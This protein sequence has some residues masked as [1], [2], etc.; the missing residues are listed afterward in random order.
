MKDSVATRSRAARALAA[1][2]VSAALVIGGN[3]SAFAAGGAGG[4]GAGAS[5]GGSGAGGVSAGGVSAGGNSGGGSGAGAGSEA[6]LQ[7]QA[8]ELAGEIQADGRN[9]DQLAEAI[10]GAQ[11]RQQQLASQSAALRA[12]MIRTGAEVAA[13]RDALKEQAVLAY[14]A[15]G[16]PLV[17]YVPGRAGQDPSLTVAYAEIVA[18]GQ[19]QV[20]DAYRS[21][22]AKQAAQ[23]TQL[24]SDQQQEAATV[25]QL[26]S[27]RVAA[28]SAQAAR[29]QALAQVKGQ[30]A[31]LVAAVQA[32]QQ[33]AEEAAVSG[34]HPDAAA[35]VAQP[36]PM[37]APAPPATHQAPSTASHLTSAPQGPAP[38]ARPTTTAATTT[39]APPPPTS[40]PTTTPPAMTTGGAPAQAPGANEAL[41]Y[42][43]AQLGKP[44]QWA[45]AGPGSFDCSGLT[46]MAW[47]QAGVYFPHLA[48]DQ[49][50]MTARIA[51][52]QAE[53]GD[54]IFFGTSDNVYHVGIYIGGG[55]MIDAPETGEVVSISSIYWSSLLGA[56]RVVAQ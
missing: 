9:L 5:G 45:G 41:A 20:V 39:T 35:P 36:T 33:H 48:Q 24:A 44:Y 16:A 6:A 54:L 37:A 15:G 8:Q 28:A 12:T 52:S 30:L 23:A 3:A 2:V 40:A 49:Y 25:G 53:P 17:N 22:L 46:M 31:T 34:S 43:R 38:P 51:L 19:K 29:E 18:K 26:E 1:A 7:I 50:D 11:I 21:V 13:A 42:A 47:E 10:D 32:A 27:D 56:G 14:L 55:Q 4:S